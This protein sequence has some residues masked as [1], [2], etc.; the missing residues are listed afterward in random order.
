MP[1]ASLRNQAISLL[2]E[3]P[4]E[5]MKNVIDILRGLRNLL[6]N[7]NDA[8]APAGKGP[9]AGRLRAWNELKKYKGIVMRGIDE[10]DELAGARDEKFADFI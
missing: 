3:I 1:V 6:A 2:D 7:L 8:E 5:Q 10:K 4:N 9:N